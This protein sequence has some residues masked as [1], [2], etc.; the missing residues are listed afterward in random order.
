MSLPVF[1][2]LAWD[3][4]ARA[5]ARLGV[6]FLLGGAIGFEREVHHRAAGLRT[7]VLVTVSAAATM[8]LVDEMGLVDSGSPSRVIQGVVAG[9]G[10]LGAGTILKLPDQQRIRGLT[11]ASGVWA[12]AAIGL[13]AGAGYL[14]LAAVT[15]TIVLFTIGIL[16]LIEK[17]AE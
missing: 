14:V 17:H 1:H 4:L 13:C 12:A 5:S 11:T 15:T 9:V 7:H 8:L 2:G 16:G 10:F 6:A 3:E